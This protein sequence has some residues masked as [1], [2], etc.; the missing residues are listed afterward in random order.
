MCEILIDLVLHHRSVISINQCLFCKVVG[1]L[2]D[3]DLEFRKQLQIL[4]P[5]VLAAENLVLKEINGT[6]VTA[7]EL[8]EYFK[9]SV[10]SG[11]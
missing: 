3:V 4:V 9:V 1:V 6:L 10:G 8:V 5:M 7:H 11:V 2:A